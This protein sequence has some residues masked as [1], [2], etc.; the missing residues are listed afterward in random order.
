MILNEPC[1][2]DKGVAILEHTLELYGLPDNWDRTAEFYLEVIQDLPM[3]VIIDA[4]RTVRL[5]CKWFPKPSEIKD[6]VHKNYYTRKIA[7]IHM[8]RVIAS[9]EKNQIEPDVNF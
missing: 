6:A 3:D 5:T 8:D 2:L 1:S 9:A 4:M 7:E